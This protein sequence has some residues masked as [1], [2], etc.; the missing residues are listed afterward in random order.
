M[1]ARF[2]LVEG[3]DVGPDIIEDIELETEWPGRTVEAES[4]ETNDSGRGMNSKLSENPTRVTLGVL[5]NSVESG[6]FAFA[7]CMA[8]SRDAGNGKF[9]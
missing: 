3:E 2:S 9:W 6:T 7:D 4:L 1:K 5:L 8:E